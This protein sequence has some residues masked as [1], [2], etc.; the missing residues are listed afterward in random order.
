MK[1]TGARYA[2]LVFLHPTGMSCS[3][4]RCVRARN[5]DA[6]FFM[7]GWTRCGSNKKHTGRCYGELVFLYP[8]QPACHIVRSGHETSTHYFSCSGGLG[9]DPTRSALGHIM[10]HLHF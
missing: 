5:V 3:A 2:K 10:M 7:L 6:L 1:R 9:A 4:F 8:V